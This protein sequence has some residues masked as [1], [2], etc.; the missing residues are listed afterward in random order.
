MSKAL[1]PISSLSAPSSNSACPNRPHHSSSKS[2]HS[3]TP[4]TKAEDE[5]SSSLHTLF[6]R[7]PQTHSLCTPHPPTL[8]V[9]TLVISCVAQDTFL[10][11]LPTHLSSPPQASISFQK[12]K[13]T[14]HYW[15]SKPGTPMT[16]EIQSN[17]QPR[18]SGLCKI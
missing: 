4:I 10:T 8:S 15:P 11:A 9:Q 17:S 18:L 7:G 14:G 1:T 6:L 5:L 3:V 13:V 16:Y 12:H 2:V